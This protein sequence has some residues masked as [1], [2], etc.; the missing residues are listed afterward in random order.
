[1]DLDL[2][3]CTQHDKSVDYEF[4][5]TKEEEY[6][7]DNLSL[8]TNHLYYSEDSSKSDY[9]ESADDLEC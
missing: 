8:K 9:L 6:D 4:S 2:A 1:M 5:S 3:Q 7:T